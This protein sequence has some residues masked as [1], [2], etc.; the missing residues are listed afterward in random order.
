MKSRTPLLPYSRKTKPYITHF[1]LP[2]SN[3]IFSCYAAR[4]LCI[5]KIVKPAEFHAS[6]QEFLYVRFTDDI[7]NSNST[8]SQSRGFC[9][10]F[11]FSPLFL[12]L[13]VSVFLFAAYLSQSQLL[14]QTSIHLPCVSCLAAVRLFSADFCQSLEL[15][16]GLILS[17]SDWIYWIMSPLNKTQNPLPELCF[18]K[19][20][21]QR[22]SLLIDQF[23]L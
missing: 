19:Q 15:K 13:H 8:H 17:I 5:V 18:E 3:S 4:F 12:M 9:F 11:I 20:W 14:A 10:S 22:K 16:I 1:V 6:K 23:L 21:L 2:K 7:P